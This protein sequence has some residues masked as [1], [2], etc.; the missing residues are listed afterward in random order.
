MTLDDLTLD[1]VQEA[2]IAADLE[3]PPVRTSDEG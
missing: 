3:A 1:T 2:D